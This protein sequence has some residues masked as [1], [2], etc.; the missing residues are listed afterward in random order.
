MIEFTGR[1]RPEGAMLPMDGNP[2]QFDSERRFF[3]VHL[4]VHQQLPDGILPPGVRP[5]KTFM[6]VP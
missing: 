3:G 5:S 2:L 1:N 6:M 4:E